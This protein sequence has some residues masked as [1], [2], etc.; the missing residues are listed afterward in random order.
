MSDN[1][2]ITGIKD[3]LRKGMYALFAISVAGIYI[4]RAFLDIGYTG[5]S[6]WSIIADGLLLMILGMIIDMLFGA[7]GI[8]DGRALQ[9]VNEAETRYDGLLKDIR[10]HF[11]L[12]DAFCHRKNKISQESARRQLLMERGYKYEDFWTEDGCLKPYTE[13]KSEPRKIRHRRYA[14]YKRARD[15]KITMLNIP[16]LVSDG[17]NTRDP[18]ATGRSISRFMAGQTRNDFFWKAIMG[19]LVGFFGVGLVKDFS[20]VNLIWTIIQ[21]AFL[22]AIGM[23]R[24]FMSRMYISREYRERINFK[25]NLLEEF[26][27]EICKGDNSN[28]D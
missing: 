9:N 11:D 21:A 17:K 19:T 6:I 23:V 12:L 5:K 4:L 8:S 13:D 3:F 25:S 27:N 7:Q 24:Y 22:L 15:F 16:F 26:K 1:K 28:V 10:K 14:A 20:F 18:N 2:F